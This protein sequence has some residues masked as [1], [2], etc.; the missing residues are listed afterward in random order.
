MPQFEIGKFYTN[1]EIAKLGGRV[2]SFLAATKDGLV[3][4]GR[5][6]EDINPRLPTVLWVGDSKERLRVAR[7]RTDAQ[8]AC[9][10]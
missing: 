4:C 3:V 7:L 10:V 2:Q 5:F 8:A 1:S 9:Y 6:K